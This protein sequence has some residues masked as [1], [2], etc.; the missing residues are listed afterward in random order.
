MRRLPTPVNLIL[1][2][3][4]PS[5]MTLLPNKVT[6]LGIGGLGLQ[7]VNVWGDTIQPIRT[8]PWVGVG[9]TG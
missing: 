4:I 2:Q 9:V 7:H 1:T 5:A 8:S 3:P 6:F